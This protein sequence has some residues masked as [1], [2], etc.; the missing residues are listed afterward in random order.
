MLVVEWKRLYAMHDSPEH[1]RPII[2][3]EPL[4]QLKQNREIRLTNADGPQLGQEFIEGSQV[5]VHR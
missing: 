3:W 5:P 4:E 1:S 2:V